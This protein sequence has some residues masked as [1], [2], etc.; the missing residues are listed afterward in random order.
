M[1]NLPIW[2]RF[3]EAKLIQGPSEGISSEI[4][5]CGTNSFDYLARTTDLE[6]QKNIIILLFH[7]SRKIFYMAGQGLMQ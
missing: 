7:L 6:L 1:P 5:Y 4:M 3:N 2:L